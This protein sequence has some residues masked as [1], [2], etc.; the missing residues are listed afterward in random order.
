MQGIKGSPAYPVL[1]LYKEVEHCGG[2]LPTSM[3]ISLLLDGTVRLQMNKTFVSF[4]RWLGGRINITS[5][6]AL[7]ANKPLNIKHRVNTARLCHRAQCVS[8]EV[9]VTLQV[10]TDDDGMR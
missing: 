1:L 5:E 10:R 2:G 6:G 8:R 7:T 3:P 4:H 9:A